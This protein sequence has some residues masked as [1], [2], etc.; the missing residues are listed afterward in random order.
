VSKKPIRNTKNN[1]ILQLQYAS[2][3]LILNR[4]SAYTRSIVYNMAIYLQDHKSVNCPP[5]SHSI[6]M[7]LKMAV[8]I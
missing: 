1:S 2:G 4:C 3:L 6:K 5:I 8:F 7:S